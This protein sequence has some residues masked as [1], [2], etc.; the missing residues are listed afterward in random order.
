MRRNGSRL[1]NVNKADLIEKIKI[2]KENHVVE[3]DKAVVAYKM[4]ALEQLENLTKKVNEGALDIELSLITP[5]NNAKN[6]DSIIEMFEWEVN[7]VVE[8]DQDEFKEYVQD[9]T[10]FAITGKMSNMAYSGK[11]GL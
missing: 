9:E 11:F 3:Y 8:L 4:E 10:H 2:N 6:Y 5:I 1:I 7:D